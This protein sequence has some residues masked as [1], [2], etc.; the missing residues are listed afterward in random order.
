MPKIKPPTLYD[1]SLLVS[2]D[3]YH[4]FYD[5]NGDSFEVING[6]LD[7]DNVLTKDSPPPGHNYVQQGALSGAGAVAGTANLDYFS[8]S[9]TTQSAGAGHFAGVGYPPS[10]PKRYVPIPGANVTFFVPYDAYG[11]LT[12]TITWT[13]DSGETTVDSQS[14]LN[15]SVTD[16]ALFIDGE[17]VLF[18]LYKTLVTSPFTR[19]VGQTYLDNALQDRYKARVW[20]GHC[21]IDGYSVDNLTPGYHTAG[22]HISQHN[23]V[24]QSRV[25]ARS[26]KYMYFKYGDS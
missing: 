20:S 15:T 11:L 22:L 9:T 6:R 16:I 14:G 4:Q 26:M 5:V 17:P 7:A 19:Q 3:I 18:G 12:W 13:N 21:F 10:S 2:E 1:N 25:R 8:G 23:T 24:K